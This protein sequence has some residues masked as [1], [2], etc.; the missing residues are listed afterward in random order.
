MQVIW[1]LSSN[2]HTVH[3]ARIPAPHNHSQ[4]NQCRTPYV[5][6]HSLVLLKMGIMMPE[7][8]WDRSLIINIRLVASC[9]FLSL[10]PAYWVLHFCCWQV[11]SSWITT[12]WRNS[13]Y[14]HVTEYSIVYYVGVFGSTV[15]WDTVLQARRMRVIFLLVSLE[16]SIG[17]IL[18]ISL[19]LWFQLSL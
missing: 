15:G 10:H 7:T 6:V 1:C 12:C 3:T 4:H 13:M 18:L 11:T 17:I 8:C 2:F 9:W 19:W 5:V 16:F 14:R